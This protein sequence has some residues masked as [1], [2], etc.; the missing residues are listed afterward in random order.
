MDGRG[1][2]MLDEA[3]RPYTYQGGTPV[4]GAQG[5][6]G[7]EV[8]ETTGFVATV[9][10][11]HSDGRIRQR[12]TRV[13][14]GLEGVVPATAVAVRL[15]D[16]V[17]QVREQARSAL[18]GR[19][20]AH[21]APQVLGVLLAGRGRQHAPAA[22]AWV[23]AALLERLPA[24]TLVQRLLVAGD[25]DVRRWAAA[26]G[27]DQG[28]LS[29]TRLLSLVRSD[30]DQWL[31]ASGAAWLLPVA[32]RQQLSALLTGNTVEAR[33]V[34]LSGL[35]DDLL[36]D[37][38]LLPLLAERAPRVREQ[39]R[40]RAARRGIDVASWYRE[41]LVESNR[42][43]RALAASLDGLGAVGGPADLEVFTA[44]LGHHSARVRAA[45]VIAVSTH[46]TRE[47]AVA[48][49]EPLLLDRS[50]RVS[51]TAARALIR[52]GAPQA[53]AEAAWASPQPWSRRAAW[54]MSR[55]AGSWD[56][57]EAD[58]RA[59]ADPDPQVASL[60]LSGIRNW[61]ATSA[62]TTWAALPEPQQARVEQ[63]LATG[64]VDSATSRLVA[65]HA[66][67]QGLARAAPDTT[68]TPVALTPTAGVPET[69]AEGPP[70]PRRWLR[71]G[72]RR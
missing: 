3:A 19:L 34:A 6:L 64:C 28:L 32:D 46:A 43:G 9:T 53:T 65:F 41:Q 17:P 7:S 35:P 56:R 16:H 36:D 66:G 24:A 71:R 51:S 69:D 70:T 37:E 58:L 68:V 48:L 30:S 47:A 15:L 61:L 42:P 55:G 29:S 11:F 62:A 21:C 33:L 63:L 26:L 72:R 52:V 54:R 39:A 67:I 23:R 12:A 38:H 4:S 45:A 25:R 50:P 14:A 2:L 18:L 59:A 10:S 22:L 5:W 27:H 1:W 13:L 44:H 57:V 49:L 31:R 20:D 8:A 40:W 60:G